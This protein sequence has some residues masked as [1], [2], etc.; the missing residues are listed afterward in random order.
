[1]YVC[2]TPGVSKGHIGSPKE[3]LA[4]GFEQPEGHY[5]QVSWFDL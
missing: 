3:M 5:G 2:L 4:R 1:M